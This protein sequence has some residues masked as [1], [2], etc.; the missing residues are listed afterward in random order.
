M[1]ASFLSV[2][3]DLER[4]CPDQLGALKDLIRDAF[5]EVH[6]PWARKM[7]LLL[8]ELSASGWSLPAD[9]NEYYFQ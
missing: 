6:E 8:L 3:Y 9:A 4:Q 7:V 2:G 1:I 5:V